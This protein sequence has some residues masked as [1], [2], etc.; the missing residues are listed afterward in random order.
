MLLQRCWRSEKSGQMWFEAKQKI[1]WN[2]FKIW[3]SQM[4]WI[5]DFSPLV[6]IGKTCITWKLSVSTK[7]GLNMVVSSWPRPRTS[8]SV[9]KSWWK[10]LSL[11]IFDEILMENIISKYFDWNLDGKDYLRI[12]LM[13]SWWKLLS[14]DILD[15]I[16]MEKIISGYFLVFSTFEARMTNFLFKFGRF[17]DRISFWRSWTNQEKDQEP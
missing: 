10:N 17:C 13:K 6:A 1:R 15:E 2:K 9:M 12:F 4:E 16:L 7:V 5:S 3:E 14:L 8:I 11:D